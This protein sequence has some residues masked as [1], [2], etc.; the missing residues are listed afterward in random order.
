M[1]FKKLVTVV[2]AQ[3]KKVQM[4]SIGEL[5]VISL[6]ESLREK[7]AI[8]EKQRIEIERL[9]SV[10][11]ALPDIEKLIHISNAELGSAITKIEQS[12]ISAI[13]NFT[14][15]NSLFSTTIN[16]TKE[17]VMGIKDKLNI[18][19]DEDT[20]NKG[21]NRN[22]Q[23]RSTDI[24]EKYEAIIN[25][26]LEE[27]KSIV[28]RKEEDIA[29]LDNVSNSVLGIKCF[30]DEVS[31]I[32]MFSQILSI[33]AKCEA[34]RAGNSGNTFSVVAAEMS[35]LS[36]ET[37]EF[38]KKIDDNLKSTQQSIENTT[39]TLKQ[40]IGV[41]SSFINA[42]VFLMR[43]VFMSIIDGLMS[44]ISLIEKTIGESSEINRSIQ[45]VIVNLQFEDITKQ[46]STH[47]MHI[48]STVVSWINKINCKDIGAH[49]E[50]INAIE[51]MANEIHEMF[52]MESERKIAV[53]VISDTHLEYDQATAI[54][55]E[56][57]SGSDDDV[58]FF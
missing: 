25:H 18:M 53:E 29:L 42:T 41:E 57:V 15:I 44:L 30:A 7:D 14:N 49:L 46:I 21:H 24:R 23:V 12:T 8:I 45:N 13:D 1:N 3:T 32:A 10:V 5:S 19:V 47:V 34:A 6:Q 11:K 43:D 56:S 58:T 52:T 48:M 55:N 16:S 9:S 22:G 50:S 38:A 40:A 20:T 17:L 26:I 39:K 51:K 28:S 33:N 36:Q 37:R 2:L 35:R 27:M 54:K 4:K 31:R